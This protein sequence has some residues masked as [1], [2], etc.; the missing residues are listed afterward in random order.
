MLFSVILYKKLKALVNL[1]NALNKHLRLLPYCAYRAII[2]MIKHDGI[3][4]A[5]YI[6][7]L[8]M[9]GIFPCVILLAV[10]VGFLSRIYFDET[11]WVVFQTAL[12]ESKWSELITPLKPRLAEI[13][14]TP[15][16]KFL[17][18]AII[19]AVWS[20]SSMIEGLRTILNRAYRVRQ[21]LPYIPGRFFSIVQFI[22]MLL[23][24]SA[25]MLVIN[26]VPIFM[27]YLGDTLQTVVPQN[28]I[29]YRWLSNITI[30]Q[31][32]ITY[33]VI[34]C[35]IV[36]LHYT[37]P[38]KKQILSHLLPGGCI[39][40]IGWYIC[41]IALKYYIKTF[42]QIDFIYGS[43]AGIVVCLFYFYMCNLVFI[44]SAEFNYVYQLAK[45]LKF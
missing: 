8:V 40:V 42:S 28:I 25:A 45:K 19:S 7:F 16:Q 26:V 11:I 38:N 9:L 10:V 23:L 37:L 6:A 20:A 31:D 17:T 27:R 2:D 14:H 4:H 30:L 24:V 12:L 29:T 13:I 34:F 32:V 43:I 21:P 18:F 5:G 39:T 36:H 41:S 15:P 44:F 35:F 1:S 33:S 3:E 22:A